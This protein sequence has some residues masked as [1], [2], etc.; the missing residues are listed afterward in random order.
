MSSR[1]EFIAGVCPV[2]YKPSDTA[3]ILMIPELTAKEA[4]GKLAGMWGPPF[5]T[6]EEGETHR[7]AIERCIFDE[8]TKVRQGRIFIPDNLQDT[9]L[10]VV[11]I[12]PPEVAAWV[13]AYSIPVSDDFEVERG[14]FNHEVGNPEWV[15]CQTV[16]EAEK[17][18]NRIV[19]KPATYEIIKAHIERLSNPGQFQHKE[20]LTPVNLPDWRIYQLI[21]GGVSQFEALFLSGVDPTPLLNSEELIRQ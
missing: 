2:L 17:G 8:E 11:R 7:Q 12:S 19:F 15:D 1:V 10:C 14:N 6:V 18:A 13:H 9:R 4:T 21:E 5:E 16:I 3:R 20:V